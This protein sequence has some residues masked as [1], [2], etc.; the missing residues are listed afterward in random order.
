MLYLDFDDLR[1]I[2]GYL[3]GDNPL[4]Q[5]DLNNLKTFTFMWSMFEA[6]ACD[7][8]GTAQTIA[9]FVFNK[10]DVNENNTSDSVIDAY[11]SYFKERYITD[12]VLNS[13]YYKMIRDT[14]EVFVRNNCEYKVSSF[15]G[16]NLL[17]DSTTE[18][19]RILT[20]LLIPYRWRTNFFNRSQDHI[21]VK[22]QYKNFSIAN[23]IIATILLQYKN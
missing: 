21:N 18:E 23:K 6:K 14:K 5:E 19:D 16:D 8:N 13:F 11:F 10:L 2:N 22:L 1:W 3:S 4:S 15:I 12:K 9:D 7:G 17:K 20:C